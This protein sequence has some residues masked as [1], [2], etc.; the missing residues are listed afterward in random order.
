MSTQVRIG[1]VSVDRCT[2]GA[3]VSLGINMVTNRSSRKENDGTYFI[4]DRIASMNAA[5]KLNFDDDD[6]DH[7]SIQE[8][9]L[10]LG[11]Y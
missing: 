2:Q 6:W 8:N 4:G 9:N 11:P 10:I 7:A 3:T 1:G 5:C